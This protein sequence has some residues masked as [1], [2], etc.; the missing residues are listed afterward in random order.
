MRRRM[1]LALV[2]CVLGS[3]RAYAFPS[4]VFDFVVYDVGTLRIKR[5]P[6]FH[7]VDQLKSPRFFARW[8]K[9]IATLGNGEACAAVPEGLFPIGSKLDKNFVYFPR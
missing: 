3:G 8:E 5:I 6:Q 1:F 4:P 7:V 9:A 2:G